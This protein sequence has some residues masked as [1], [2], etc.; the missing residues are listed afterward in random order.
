MKEFNAA[1]DEIEK[2]LTQAAPAQSAT[3]PPATVSLAPVS[4]TEAKVSDVK[5]RTSKGDG[6]DEPI[7]LPGP[8]ARGWETAAI[9]SYLGL[10]H[11]GKSRRMKQTSRLSRGEYLS[12]SLNK[13]YDL[14]PTRRLVAVLA[15]GQT[16]RA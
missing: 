7:L 1:R 5:K 12:E 3:V 14:S 10:F 13:S 9:I 6:F 16:A 8:I 15:S 4:P 11:F 2:E